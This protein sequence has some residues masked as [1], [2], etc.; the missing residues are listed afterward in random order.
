[1]VARKPA[2]ACL[3]LAQDKAPAKHPRACASMC[4]A[5][6]WPHVLTP[7][8]SLSESLLSRP[9]D[10]LL[11][12][13]QPCLVAVSLRLS[14]YCCGSAGLRMAWNPREDDTF[15]QGSSSITLLRP[16]LNRPDPLWLLGLSGLP[17]TSSCSFTPFLLLRNTLYPL[18]ERGKKW[19]CFSA[20]GSRKEVIMAVLSPTQHLPVV[21][22]AAVSG[23]CV[24]DVVPLPAALSE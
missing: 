20:L 6:S 5:E 13:Q 8:C 3:L 17:T 14:C 9:Q 16:H 19:V 23:S 18:K 21:P 24:A 4:P 10:S 7:F 1:M 11:H 2:E 22:G 15:P 12:I